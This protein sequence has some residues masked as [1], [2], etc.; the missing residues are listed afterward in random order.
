[1]W[2]SDEDLPLISKYVGI[3]GCVGNLC[4]ELTHIVIGQD[5]SKY[6]GRW[7]E[8]PTEAIE[9]TDLSPLTNFSEL[10]VLHLNFPYAIN[11]G[12]GD[13]QDFCRFFTKLERLG[14][15]STPTV[16]GYEPKLTP[17]CLEWIAME[18]PQIRVLGLFMD[19]QWTH[20]PQF[21]LSRRSTSC[22]DTLDVGHS[23]I[24]WG[25]D[26]SY[27]ESDISMS[28]CLLFPR[29]RSIETRHPYYRELYLSDRDLGHISNVEADHYHSVK[30]WERIQNS[31]PGTNFPG[32]K[33]K[34]C[35]RVRGEP[36]GA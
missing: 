19:S 35:I 3:I 14:L 21:K 24:Q 18:R 27:E 25:P 29:L 36:W 31:L 23:K 4:N 32:Q 33:G 28:L 30:G 20:Y 34:R 15:C 9:M 12:N 7:S 22:L 26:R 8:C 17:A 13:L 6:Q 2:I 5:W 16:G 11:M 10:R 1:M